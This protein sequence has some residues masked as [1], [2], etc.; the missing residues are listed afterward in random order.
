MRAIGSH[1]RYMRRALVLLLALGCGGDKDFNPDPTEPP[2]DEP[3]P[4]PPAPV[5][6][7]AF[8]NPVEM[9]DD[10][11]ALRALKI[12]GANVEGASS[13]SCNQCHNLTRQELRSWRALSDTA[14]SECLTD[15]AVPAPASARTMI[16]CL[17]A[18][19]AVGTSDFQARKL[20]I[21]AAGVRLPWFEFTAKYGYGAS[22]GPSAAT[23]LVA[24]A[25]MPRNGDT[26]VPLTQEQFDVVAEWFVRGLPELDLKLPPD[27]AP[28]SCRLAVSVEVAGHVNLMKTLGWRAINT[29]SLMAMHGCGSA[30]DPRQCLQSVPLGTDQSYGLGWDLPGRGRLRVLADETYRSSYWTRSSPDGRFIAHGVQNVAGSYIIDLQRGGQL[31]PIDVQYDPAWFPDNS[32]FIFQGGPRNTCA[33][34]LLTSNPE[35]I[36]MLEPQCTRLATVGLYQHVGAR[37]GGDHFAVDSRF[38]SDD[39]GHSLT[40]SDPPASFSSSATLSFTPIIYDG[41]GYTSK[42]EVTVTTPFEGDFVIAPSAKLVISRVAGPNSAQLGYVLRKVVATPTGGT[43]SMAVPEVARY[44]FSGGKP[45]F[46]YDERWI[47]YHHYVTNTDADAKELGFVDAADPGFA[48]YRSRGAANTYLL[49]LATGVTRRITNMA[50]GQ[51]ALYPHFRSDGWIYAVVRDTVA[52]HEYMV[53]SDGALLAE[54]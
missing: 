36:T 31:V 54:Q 18:M 39:G 53:A 17:R 46:S 48:P 20:G 7:P 33:Q 14:L 4:P 45:A 44:C 42:Q 25:G 3:G 28:T 50:P 9:L 37:S 6:V 41:T 40:T 13:T 29:S 47:V 2:P 15:L 12:L 34:S 8:R 11:L 26:A 30:T 21:Y 10:E 27:P 23:D 43:Y 49:E 32:G 16:D 52:N 1:G 35:R 5:V 38:V 22:A 24:Q 51:Y 19:P